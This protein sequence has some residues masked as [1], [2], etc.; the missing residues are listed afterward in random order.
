MTQGKLFVLALSLLA[1]AAA[2]ADGA[3]DAPQTVGTVIG[4]GLSVRVQVAPKASLASAGWLV[5]EFENT[6]QE[7]VTVRDASYRIEADCCDP[8]TGGERRLLRGLSS[9]NTYDLFPDAWKTRPVS[10][11]VLRPKEVHR[12]AGQTSDYASAL[13]GLA[14]KDGWRVRARLHITVDLEGGGQLKTVEQGVPFEFDW[15]YP[16]EAGFAALRG[17]LK[18]LLKEPEQKATHTYILGALLR[19]EAVSGAVA[20]DDLLAALAKREGSFDGRS[21]VAKHL[22]KHH[23]KDPGVIEFVRECLKAGDAGATHYD[24]GAGLWDKSFVEP[25]VSLYESA[26]DRHMNLLTVLHAHRADWHQN[27]GI[28]ARLSKVV[29]KRMPLLERKVAELKEDQ[30]SDWAWGAHELG[31]TGD[32]SVIA[33]LRPALDDRRAFRK[34]G[35][36]AFLPVPPHPLR[37]CDCALDAILTLLDGG[38]HEAYRKAGGHALGVFSGKDADAAIAAVRDKMIDDL[39]RRLADAEKK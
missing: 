11:I 6:G 29:R 26:A 33:S 28:P 12:V 2:E 23:G 31:L 7:A 35:D 13:L 37:V 17:R 10:P 27:A 3:D 19:L 9:G 24:L 18:T 34:A 1:S 38:P 25:L 8:K 5:L 39:K 4:P 21:E 16:D 15:V 20:R 30:L 22:A 14:P 36:F 32:R